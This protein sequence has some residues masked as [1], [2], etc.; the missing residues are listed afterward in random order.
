MSLHVTWSPLIREVPTRYRSASTA[1]FCTAVTLYTHTAKRTRF[2][3]PFTEDAFTDRRSTLRSANS[4]CSSFS[5]TFGSLATIV[6]RFVSDGSFVAAFA[7][8]HTTGML[9]GCATLARNHSRASQSRFLIQG[10]GHHVVLTVAAPVAPRDDE[11][12]L[13]DRRRTRIADMPTASVSHSVSAGKQ[14]QS[15]ATS[16]LRVYPRCC[17]TSTFSADGLQALHLTD[18][19]SR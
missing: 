12:M 1:A 8:L 16:P 3:S 2:F 4:F 14:Q 9:R 17:K 7:V 13:M 10:P 19:P 5:T 15:T 11:P 6:A 18:L